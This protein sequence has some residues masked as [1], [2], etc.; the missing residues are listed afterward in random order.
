MNFN[1][2]AVLS[3]CKELGI[4]ANNKDDMLDDEAIILLDNTMNIINTDEEL[5][6]DET[7]AIDN[8]VE[9]IMSKDTINQID[10]KH[11]VSKEKVKKGNKN[12]EEKTDK[13]YLNKKKQM[14]KNKEKLTSNTNASDSNIILYKEGMSV[15][16][17][18]DELG[19]TGID[20]VKKLI[21]LGLILSVTQSI[22]Y[23]TAEIVAAEY[24]KTLK[25]E[26]TQD[27]SNF[28]NYE[29]Q[30]DEESLISR[31]P[32]ITIMGH[33]DHIVIY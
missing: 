25:R 24:E 26:E 5:S 1:V 9:D 6:F 31:P 18:A 12:A 28:E 15:Q 22:D 7:D 2:Q 27:I 30:D 23:D 11:T 14:Y 13:E 4:K 16:D 29:I 32:V 17:L 19:I 20:L 33:V 3:K 10:K 8:V 21:S